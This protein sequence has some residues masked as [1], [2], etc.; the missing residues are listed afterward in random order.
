MQCSYDMPGHACSI[1]I[2]I[3]QVLLQETLLPKE[4][5]RQD[6]QPYQVAN[7]AVL[8]RYGMLIPSELH[9]FLI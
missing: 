2:E 4:L 6:R 9:P 8:Q 3:L 1:S 7:K 5:T